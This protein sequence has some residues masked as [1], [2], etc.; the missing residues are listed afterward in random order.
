[1]FKCLANGTCPAEDAVRVAVHTSCTDVHNGH[2]PVA[3]MPGHLGVPRPPGHPHRPVRSATDTPE[4]L[5]EGYSAIKHLGN[6]RP[7]TSEGVR[8]VFHAVRVLEAVGGDGVE[9]RHRARATG[10]LRF[11][12]EQRVEVI[13]TGAT[14]RDRRAA[15]WT[16][17]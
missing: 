6:A 10:D 11:Q 17:I 1:W 2:R 9:M 13:P 16:N 5:G 3:A 8:G 14:V 15:L 7:K 4:N 12:Q